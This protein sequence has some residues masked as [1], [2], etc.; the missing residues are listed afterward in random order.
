MSKIR[1]SARGEECQVRIPGVCNHNPETTVWAHLPDGTGG[2]M[3]GKSNDLCG[4]YAC[5]ACHDEI[6]GRTRN[7][8]ERPS[9]PLIEERFALKLMAYEGH[10]RSLQK[11][12]DKGLICITR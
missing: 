2:K 3:G 1:K 11:L 7:F 12:L 10:M 6:D 4:T 8:Y 5:S 9:E